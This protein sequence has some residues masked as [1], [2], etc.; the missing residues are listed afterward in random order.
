MIFL[1][2]IH[3]YPKTNYAFQSYQCL[4]PFIVTTKCSLII[5]QTL[6]KC[7]HMTSLFFLTTPMLL[8]FGFSIE[9]F[10]AVGMAYKYEKMRTLLGP[11]LCFILVWCSDLDL[12]KI[13]PFSGCSKLC[14][15]L[16]F[17]SRWTI[18]GFFHLVFSS[19]KYTSGSI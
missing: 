19:P 7:G 18:H 11:I 17:V 5:D 12:L 1:F 6:Y 10:V 3:L 2:Y 8:P 15:I 14:R 9:R 4:I 16:F 13:F